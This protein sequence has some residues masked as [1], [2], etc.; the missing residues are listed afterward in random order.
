M[1]DLKLLN[2]KQLIEK[3]P[4]L[5]ARPHRVAWLVRSFLIPHVRIGRNV[6]FEETAIENWIKK[7]R[8][9]AHEIHG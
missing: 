4:G 8:I 2:R 3:H 1:A 6:Y 5:G 9:S 7:Q